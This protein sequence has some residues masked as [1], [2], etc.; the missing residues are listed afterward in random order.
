MINVEDAQNRLLDFNDL[1]IWDADLRSGALNLCDRAKH[2]LGLG[3]D[4]PLQIADGLMRIRKFQ[5]KELLL[6]LKISGTANAKFRH[7][8]SLVCRDKEVPKRISIMGH[9]EYDNGHVAKRVIGIIAEAAE[10]VSESVNKS[11]LLAI[12]SHE[13]KSPLTTIKLYIQ[14]ADKIAKEGT[15]IKMDKYLALAV[16]EVDSMNLLMENFLDLTAIENGGIRLA[17]QT[18]DVSC[19]LNE[20]VAHW[21][22]NTPDHRFIYQAGA[23]VFISADLI[24]IKQVLHNLLSNAVKYSANATDISVN[25]VVK[26]AHIEICIRDQGEGISEIDQEKLFGRFSRVG[27]QQS[28]RIDGH[29]MGLF[30]VREIVR[31]HQ[32]TVW[33]Q[34]QPGHG[35]AFY[36]SLPGVIG[37]TSPNEEMIIPRPL[38]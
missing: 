16:R 25:C 23:S 35:T 26:H 6:K 19:L 36:F 15:G 21:S 32:G 31:K 20:V 34:S 11:D 8:V 14:L 17:R 13:L 4:K 1:G 27:A 10:Q 5:R 3:S 38:Y 9:I 18:F 28:G 24:K 29:G 30:L 33:L 12:V 2:I 37:S 22:V 7:E